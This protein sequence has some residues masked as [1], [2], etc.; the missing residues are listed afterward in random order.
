MGRKDGR[1]I[2][3]D[4]D[5]NYLCIM[6]FAEDKAHGPFLRLCENGN[7]RMG[8]YKMGVR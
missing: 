6:R 1:G 2:I 8:R 3:I 4:T 5:E 7:K